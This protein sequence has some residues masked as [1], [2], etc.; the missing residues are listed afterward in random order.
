MVCRI[1]F[2]AV[3]AVN[4][5]SERVGLLRTGELTVDRKPD[6]LRPLSIG[7]RHAKS[8]LGNMKQGR[9]S[10]ADLIQSVE[11]E[12]T[13][14]QHVGAQLEALIVQQRF[15]EGERLPPE[16]E[17][18][19]RFRVSRTVV[20]E[21]VRGLAAK[22][23][24]EVKAGSG[25]LVRAPSS[26]T[27]ADSMTLLLSMS[28]GATPDKVVEVRR[29]I[30][31]E[32]AAL[33]ALRRTDEDLAA[34]EEILRTAAGN[35]EDPTTFI[36]TDVAFHQALA[37]ATQNELFSAMLASIVNVMV[38]VRVV[39][40]GVPGTPERALSYHQDIF[41]FVQARDSEGAR[42]AMQR[43]MDE[44]IETMTAGLKMLANS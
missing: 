23:L 39:G 11:R 3:G 22:G 43:H 33:A 19:E 29:I 28:G 35:L 27:V 9:S 38:E 20:R 26:Q 10:A 36:D 6:T 17:L 4:R 15:R 42:S 12:A 16:R 32:I 25:T 2:G 18:A 14:A 8:R 24:L 7:M 44:A 5:V 30:E 1:L 40:L 37:Q 31:A 34:M 41:R 13:L 21:A